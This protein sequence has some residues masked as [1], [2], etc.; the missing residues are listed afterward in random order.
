MCSTHHAQQKS[1]L[2][3]GFI[4]FFLSEFWIYLCRQLFYFIYIAI[5]YAIQRNATQHSVA[6]SFCSLIS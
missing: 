6:R 4:L 5:A 2:S 3:S 1:Q